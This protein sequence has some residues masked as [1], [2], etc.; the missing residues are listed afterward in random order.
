MPIPD[1]VST[2]NAF[3]LGV[4]SV[5]P[6]ATV[7]AVWV[8]EWYNPGRER[9]AA[10]ALVGQGVDVLGSA[11]QDSPAV[12][13][14]AESKGIWSI[15]MFSDVSRYAPKGL[16]TSITHD[17]T[18]YLRQAV[19]DSLAGTF[20]G[21]PYLASLKNKGV[22]LVP[23][24]KA[25]PASVVA[26]AQRAE[27]DIVSGKLQPFA[28]PLKDSDGKVRAASGASLSDRDIASMN[29]FVQGIQGSVPH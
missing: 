14:Y 19:S 27:A 25:V 23:W 7:K 18:P 10:Q 17:W 16:I 12:V 22:G 1:V 28:G 26:S 29:W 4:H 6:G 5:N 15:G 3:A 8:N 2:I 24:N 21:T 20:K 13:Q 9:E 11:F